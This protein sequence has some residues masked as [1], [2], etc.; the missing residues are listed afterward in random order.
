M[1]LP[2]TVRRN[3]S[4]GAGSGSVPEPEP[5]P[6]SPAL[7]AS[8]TSSALSPCPALS[9]SS[10]LAGCVCQ[11]EPSWT[12][13]DFLC[14]VVVVL[15]DPPSVRPRPA[16]PPLPGAGWHACASVCACAC[17]IP[18]SLQTKRSIRIRIV[19]IN[20]KNKPNLS[21]EAAALA[22]AERAGGPRRSL[23]TGA[24]AR[25][26]LCS[27]VLVKGPCVCYLGETGF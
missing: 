27:V 2:Q 8:T 12:V 13:V 5:A 24:S 18:S 19:I 25:G 11:G 9:P 23:R 3:I 16:A 21:Q 15:R 20:N 14:R 17:D 10:S 1:I 4:S 22:A 7:A 6:G 26:H